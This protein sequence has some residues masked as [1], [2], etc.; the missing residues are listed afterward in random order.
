MAGRTRVQASLRPLTDSAVA[1]P[2]QGQFARGR[3]LIAGHVLLAGEEHRIDGPGGSLWDLPCGPLADAARHG[4]GWLA[5][6]GAVGDGPARETARRWVMDWIARYGRG[7]GPGWRP[8][9]TGWRLLHWTAQ[10]A[11]IR[12]GISPADAGAFAQSLTRQVLFLS[13]RWK[14]APP[15]L[16]RV[17]ALAG[18]IHGALALDGHGASVA[19]GAEALARHCVALV[20]PGGAIPSR[21]PEDLCEIL[22]LLIGVTGAL[23]AAGESVPPALMAATRRIAPTLRALRHADGGL[24]RFHGGGRG[25]EGRLD[26]ALAAV[27]DRSRRAGLAMGFARLAAG[28]ST[29]IMD[30]GAP[31][32]GPES[33]RAHAA[34]LAFEL[35]S[36]R[37]PVVVNCGAGDSFGPDW[38][39]AGRAT[40]S[41]STL[42]LDGYSS[43]RFGAGDS[44][45]LTEV[46]DLVP[47]ESAV[48]ATSH[49]HGAAHNGWQRTHGLT[50]ARTLDLTLDGRAL[51]GEELLVA[52][53]DPDKAQFDRMLAT[54]PGGIG[55][56]LRFH[57][58]PETEA[59]LDMG[60]SAISI[61][62][63]SGEVWVFRQEGASEMALAP[64]V[65]LESGRKAP[66]PTTQVVLSG[67]AMAY[68]T[69]VRWSLAKA[70][71]TPSALRD[72]GPTAD[73]AD[74]NEG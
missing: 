59:H 7:R 69:R 48:T 3:R 63:K 4:C 12:R 46:P 42:G 53:S 6:L 24:A 67:R 66:R 70:Q 5:D 28:R 74:D 41:Q 35:T 33:G 18:L 37:R 43:S 20:D 73:D 55:W 45:W 21:S 25:A 32:R 11:L 30:A 51:T 15:G 13:R 10:A 29:V 38:R 56:T 61:A 31:P 60:G 62:L 64:S 72:L 71:D 52:L 50:H 16:P 36:G 8:G 19:A 47:G 54:S 9:V 34:T 1:G 68:A 14:A 22:S 49:R 58:H 17:A 27:G 40:A 2:F 26:A 65:H 57:L 44:D 23:T 39:R